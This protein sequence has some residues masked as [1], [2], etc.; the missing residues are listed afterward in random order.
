MH[1]SRRID[2]V[3]VIVVTVC[4]FVCSNRLPAQT[5]N[6]ND[7]SVYFA[8]PCIYSYNGTY[9]LYGTTEENANN[10]FVAYTSADL[11]SWKKST[12][13]RGYALMKGNA[14]GQ[15]RFWAPQV[16]RF[17]DTFYMAYAAD[18]Q[19]AIAKSV[20]P[21]GPFVQQLIA[22]LS[23]PVKQIDPFVF[24]DEDGKKYLYHV[25]LTNG[26]RIFVAEMEDDFSAI[27]PSTLKECITATEPWENTANS[28]WSVT[29]G[30]S[31]IKQKGVYYLFYTANDYRNP[32]YAV[33]YATSNSPYGPWNK[34]SGSPVISRK[35]LGINGT[36][37][38]DFFRD[39]ENNLLYVFHTHFSDQRVGP[40]KTAVIKLRFVKDKKAGIDKVVAEV[41]TFSYLKKAVN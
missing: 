9:Y 19:I 33:G 26:N 20:H 17:K 11:L 27:K 35:L 2:I 18:E 3:A 12:A 39:A 15:S 24:I 30:P 13:Q 41:S 29:E 6:K 23:A 16:F 36:G 40:R 34:Y 37:H 32:D 1:F 14:F 31:V 10:G 38:G 25:R 8:D 5:V 28:S 7:T 22:P 21:A 4:L